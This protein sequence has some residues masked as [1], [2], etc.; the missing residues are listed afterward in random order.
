MTL[1]ATYSLDTTYNQ[2]DNLQDVEYTD[3]ILNQ[4]AQGFEEEQ[5]E[6]ERYQHEGEEEYAEEY[7][8]DNNVE[9]SEE[10][11]DYGGDGYQDEVLDIHINE[12]LDGEFQV[13]PQVC[14][15]A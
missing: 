10:Q 8:Q 12:P 6:V 13:S 9:L 5:A 7:G 4:D 11:M 2:Q 14:L 1:N 3:D 15:L